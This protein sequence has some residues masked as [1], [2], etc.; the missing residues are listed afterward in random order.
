MSLFFKIVLISLVILY[1]ISIIVLLRKKRLN[2][3]YALLWILTGVIMLIVGVL[4]QS[5]TWFFNLCGIEVF[6][7]GLFAMLI[8]F[9]LLI[10]LSITCIVSGLNEKVRRLT[11]QCALLEKRI[12]E[13]ENSEK[14]ND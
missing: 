8:F 14:D 11:Q 10:L 13:L 7:N 3:K 4:P 9:I 1:L 12:R 5:L 2:L 6:T